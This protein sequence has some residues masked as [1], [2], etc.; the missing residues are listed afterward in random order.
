MSLIFPPL[1]IFTDQGQL[2]LFQS[3]IKVSIA[4]DTSLEQ[5][6]VSDDNVEVSENFF[7][8]K[9]KFIALDTERVARGE[10]LGDP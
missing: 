10:L 3:I 8:L 5:V 4:Q 6:G 7:H 2:C 1:D 9:F